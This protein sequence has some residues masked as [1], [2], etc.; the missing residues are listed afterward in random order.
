MCLIKQEHWG[1]YL[2]YFILFYFKYVM[3][4][5]IYI[6]ISGQGQ[7]DLGLNQRPGINLDDHVDGV[8]S[9]SEKSHL[10]SRLLPPNSHR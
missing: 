8:L 3:N 6:Y 9:S 10:Q 1:F 7:T 2:F 4:I 5:Y